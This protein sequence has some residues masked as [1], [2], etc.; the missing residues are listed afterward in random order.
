MELGE[1]DDSTDFQPGDLRDGFNGYGAHNR[2]IDNDILPRIPE[3][4]ISSE[5]H[6]IFQE[7]VLLFQT[8]NWE[9]CDQGGWGRAGERG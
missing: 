3:W 6:L 5:T 8:E 2:Y 7:G 9:E 4:M 1:V